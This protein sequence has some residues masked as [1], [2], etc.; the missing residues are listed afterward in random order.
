MMMITNEQFARNLKV[1]KARIPIK[2]EKI[3]FKVS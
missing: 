1:L 2:S 3:H